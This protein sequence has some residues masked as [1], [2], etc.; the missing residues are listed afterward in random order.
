M[1]FLKV[2]YMNTGEQ[3][4]VPKNDLPT[5]AST[6]ISYVARKNPYVCFE[7]AY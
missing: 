4:I 6:S 7:R 2:G 1:L 5:L 3:K